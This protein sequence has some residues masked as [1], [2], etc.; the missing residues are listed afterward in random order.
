MSDRNATRT[1]AAKRSN[2]SRKIVFGEQPNK[3]S[4]RSLQTTTNVAQF[5]RSSTKS[6]ASSQDESTANAASAMLS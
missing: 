4:V 2:N 5:G 6:T 1:S 3:I